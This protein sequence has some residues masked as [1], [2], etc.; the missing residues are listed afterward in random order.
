[1]SEGERKRE[2]GGETNRRG[3]S[4]V[5]LGPTSTALAAI[6]NVAGEGCSK[7]STATCRRCGWASQLL[8]LMDSC[9]GFL[10]G[11][12]TDSWPE[13]SGGPA[14]PRSLYRAA[15]PSGRDT[16]SCPLWA[17]SGSPSAGSLAGAGLIVS[18]KYVMVMSADPFAGTLT[19][20]GM[21]QFSP[22]SE[23]ERNQSLSVGLV[24]LTALLSALRARE[25]NCSVCVSS[26]G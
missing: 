24:I 17:E 7:S 25:E 5:P 16:K 12:S 6:T 3:N 10:A 18:G 11:V 22:L 14:Y 19:S 15:E 9:A 2:R 21:R 4:F 13:H 23:G 20:R 8:T 26:S 1:M